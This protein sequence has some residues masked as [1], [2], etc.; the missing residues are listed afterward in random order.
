MTPNTGLFAQPSWW[1]M[2][3]T[4]PALVA[5]F[6]A[7]VFALA[8]AAIVLRRLRRSLPESDS[9][10]LRNTHGT[11]TI[12][13]VLVFPIVLF[14][15]LLL[16]QTTMLMSGNIFVH[17]SAFAA[18]RAAIVQIPTVN[19]EEKSNELIDAGGHAKHD[20]IRR[21]ATFALLPVAG[22]L[23][24]SQINTAG[25]TDGLNAHFDAYGR[26][27]PGWI[28]RI[29]AKRYAYADMNTQTKVYAIDIDRSIPDH[30]IVNFVEP[31][32]TFGPRD[33]ITVRVAHRLA[34][35]VPYVSMLYADG[36]HT[37]D[38]GK[39]RYTS[40]EAQY[41]LTNE[42]VVDALPPRPTK[43]DGSVLDRTP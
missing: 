36:V 43:D 20:A 1:Q 18:T 11:A 41:T 8:L 24:N 5:T 3:L 37:V 22:E 30:P 34:L 33:P 26:P 27:R 31:P 42:G 38:T 2:L 13:F 32:A 15:A 21:A 4:R 29:I 16:A 10:L 23:E 14:V 7:S 35:T 17:Y 28:D 12:E 39:G 19:V 6:I 9:N 25:L 40:I